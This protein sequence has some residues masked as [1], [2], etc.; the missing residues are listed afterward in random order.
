MNYE[1]TFQIPLTLTP[2]QMERIKSAYDFIEE[3]GRCGIY[4]SMEEFI[5]SLIN[6]RLL[7]HI[8]ENLEYETD[9]KLFQYPYNR[10]T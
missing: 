2:E 9:L 1:F 6:F 10:Q 8:N 5:E 4:D 3:N 7:R